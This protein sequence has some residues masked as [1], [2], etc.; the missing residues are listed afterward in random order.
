MYRKLNQVNAGSQY[1]S[2]IAESF[3]TNLIKPVGVQFSL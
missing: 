3:A 1:A 2:D